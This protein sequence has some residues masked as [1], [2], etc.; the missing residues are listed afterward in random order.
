MEQSATAWLLQN[1]RFEEEAEA[2][3]VQLQYQLTILMLL[4]SRDVTLVDL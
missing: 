1:Y 4:L 2:S 3:L